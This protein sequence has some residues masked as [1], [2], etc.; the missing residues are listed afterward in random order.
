MSIVPQREVLVKWERHK[1]QSKWLAKR[2]MKMD[3][4]PKQRAARMSECAEL[5]RYR[6]CPSC[7]KAHVVETKLCRDRVCPV[8]SWRLAIQRYREMVQVLDLM[9]PEM[10]QRQSKV[11]MLTLTVRNVPVEQLRSCM[12]AMSAA[13]NNFNRTAA[14]K[15]VMGWARCAEITYNTKAKTVHPHYHILLVYNGPDV[16]I[17]ETM[18][19]LKA[20]WKSAAALDYNP[21]IDLCEAYST[22]G[23]DD[24]IEAAGEAF[25]YSIKPSTVANMPNKALEV[26]LSEIAGL[27]FVSY[28]R[29]IKELRKALGLQDELNEEEH[30]P[31]ICECGDKLEEIA[32][33]WAAGGYRNLE[34]VGESA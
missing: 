21:I 29:R 15:S 34:K 19:Q 18:K 27:R 4:I 8:C 3:S 1:A 16:N 23:N 11:C 30:S 31:D 17:G 25:A 26:F 14:F 6:Y 10:E 33:V 20:G 5:V 12:A 13:W 22:S 2:M 32:L 24:V 7:G 9:R 28:G